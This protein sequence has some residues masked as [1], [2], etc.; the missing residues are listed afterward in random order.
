[1]GWGH[2]M[3][4]Y[5]IM[6]PFP[7]FGGKRNAAE[8]VWDA[9]GDVG[10]YIEPFAGSAAVLLGRPP[11]KGPRVETIN[12]V[13]G[14]LVNAWRAMKHDP[15]GVAKHAYGPTIEADYHARRAW[16]AERDTDDLVA[17][18]SGSPEAYD[19]KAAG[20]WL[21]VSATAIAA[22]FRHGPWHV[23]NGRLVKTARSRNGIAREIPHISGTNKGILRRMPNSYGDT[24]LERVETYLRKI[25]T[26][27]ERVRI[28]V[29][30][31]KRVTLPSLLNLTTGPGQT[32]MFL[33]PPYITSRGLYLTEGEVDIAA[34]VLNWCREA[35]PHLRIVLAGYNNDNDALLDHGWHK[36]A[37]ISGQGHGR[38]SDPQA[39]RRER[40]WFSPSC[41]NSDDALPIWDLGGGGAA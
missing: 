37:S 7:Y 4:D 40:L 2:R 13:D 17:W 6:P 20:W 10:G 9:L 1:M 15:T 41:L 33:D 24:G 28:T 29:G 16:L 32:G 36:Q 12:D 34:E 21:Y 38:H 14:W 39:G 22:P 31:W 30:D 3:P 27:L 8:T 18:L 23:K 5:Q 25:Q 11:F 35:P 19:A 26:R